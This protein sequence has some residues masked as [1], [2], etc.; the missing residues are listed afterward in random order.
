MNQ[1]H[2][3]RRTHITAHVERAKQKDEDDVK[4]HLSERSARHHPSEAG[5]MLNAERGRT[6]ELSANIDQRLS[7]YPLPSIFPILII[8][9]ASI[10]SSRSTHI[11]TQTKS[12]SLRQQQCHAGASTKP[13]AIVVPSDDDDEQILSPAKRPRTEARRST[14]SKATDERPVARERVPSIKPK[15]PQ[16]ATLANINSGI[17]GDPKTWEFGAPE[18]NHIDLKEMFRQFCDD[19][20]LSHDQTPRQR[21]TKLRE[22]EDMMNGMDSKAIGVSTPFSASAL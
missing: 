18:A 3:G 22:I 14:K 7:P 19:P 12:P 9:M 16:P 15:I 4:V 6:F 2:S 10:P 5:R 13:D 17:F 20:T 1:K 8:S 21:A 11:R